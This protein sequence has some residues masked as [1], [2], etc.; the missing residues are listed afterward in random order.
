MAIESVLMQKVK[1]PIELIIGEDNSTDDT[2]KIVLDYASKHPKIIKPSFRA[3]NLGMIVN[4]ISTIE[5]CKGEYIAFLEGDDYW[6]DPYKLQ[7]QVDYLEAN[8]EYGMVHTDANVVNSE[9]EV[10][11]T[12][13]G[14]KPTGEILEDLL[15]KAFIITCTV[16][17]RTDIVK[18]LSARVAKENLWYTLDYW[19]WAHCAMK[20]KVH[21]LQE[22][23]TSYRSHEMGISRNKEFFFQKRLPLIVLDIVEV[24]LAQDNPISLSLAYLLSR[25][26]NSAMLARR[27]SF[28][29]KKKFL[30][31]I[32]RYPWLLFGIIPAIISKIMNKIKSAL[33]V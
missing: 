4:F 32:K 13:N 30:K 14:P 27:I 18:T 26:Y 16:F 24:R 21:H 17:I 20:S 25:N 1:F 8:V 29:E 23:T 11:F 6:I 22:A 31:L 15:K 2:K 33:K 5:E 28:K 12:S 9:N 10:I 7:K 3:S 19:F